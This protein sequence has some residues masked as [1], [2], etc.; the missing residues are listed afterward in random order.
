MEFQDPR[1]QALRASIINNK[2]E[3]S[4]N[5]RV[6]MRRSNPYA[7]KTR[8]EPTT[9]AAR[10][11]MADGTNPRRRSRAGDKHMKPIIKV[12]KAM[13]RTTAA[14]RRVSVKDSNASMKTRPEQTSIQMPSTI[15]SKPA[16]ICAPEATGLGGVVR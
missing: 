11:P 10:T 14:T 8:S 6:G 13:M 2:I 4:P 1:G 12:A 15:E 3:G 5:S 9:A 16:V 7:L